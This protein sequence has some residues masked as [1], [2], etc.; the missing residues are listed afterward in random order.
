MKGKLRFQAL[1]IIPGKSRR[2]EL[3]YFP[4]PALYNFTVIGEVAGSKVGE[5]HYAGQITLGRDGELH[6]VYGVADSR[7]DAKARLKEWASRHLKSAG[8]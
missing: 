3:R 7:E 1:A 4:D 5:W 2:S 6:Q 8:G